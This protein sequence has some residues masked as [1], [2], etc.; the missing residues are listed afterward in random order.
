MLNGWDTREKSKLVSF[1]A[2]LIELEFD[3][4]RAIVQVVTGWVVNQELDIA[5]LCKR[6][7]ERS[8]S[9]YEVDDQ[10][11]PVSPMLEQ[12]ILYLHNSV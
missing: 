12:A 1:V 2:Q 8:A 6:L 3:R 7:D 5:G 9:T 10:G 11:Q 4:F